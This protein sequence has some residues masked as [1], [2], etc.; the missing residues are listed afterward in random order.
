[1]SCVMFD[2]FVCLTIDDT[3]GQQGGV[4][5]DESTGTLL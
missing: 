2:V 3:G 1:M 5:V 4:A